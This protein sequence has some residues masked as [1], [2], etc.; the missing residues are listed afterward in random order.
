M[1]EAPA[2]WRTSKTS[3]NIYQSTR[4]NTARGS[5]LYEKTWHFLIW[6]RKQKQGDQKVSV[7]LMI[8]VQKPRKNTQSTHKWWFK[9]GH[10]RINSECGPCYTEH[11]LREQVG[12]SIN[13]WRLTGDTLNITCNFLCRNHQVHRDFWS[14]CIYNI[15][16]SVT[17]GQCAQLSARL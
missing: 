7:H 4:R 10:Q 6:Q 9:D 2:L 13:V 11:G 17:S 3:V 14:P 15:T 8:T 1:G 5:N 16:A 12:V